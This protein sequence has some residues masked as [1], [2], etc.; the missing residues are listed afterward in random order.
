M[1]RV[2]VGI[3]AA[4]VAEPAVADDAAD[5][6]KLQEA[7]NA[8]SFHR[9]DK[10]AAKGDKPTLVVTGIRFVL[11]TPDE[12]Y[13]GV[14]RIDAGRSPRTIDLVCKG[15]ERRTLRGIYEWDGN[16]LRL[17]VRAGDRPDDF[18]PRP[19]DA[20]VIGLSPDPGENPYRTARVGDWV[21]Y[22]G[23]DVVM[24]HTVTAKTGETLTLT[25]D[26]TVGGKAGP[27]IE[28]PIDLTRPYPPP[29]APDPDVTTKHERLEV[30]TE[31]L[32]LGGKRYPCER[33]KA[34]TTVTYKEE[35]KDAAIVSVGTTWHCKDVPLG[36]AVKTET[37]LADG[38]KSVSVLSGYGRGK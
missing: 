31:T 23:G 18:R 14:F 36:G 24:R 21:E 22:A 27:A 3:L 25:I 10:A 29:A 35:G 12:T 26:Q 6:R 20:L 13:E 16:A 1:K 33:V 5:V 34:R 9:G 4:V 38:T 37:E 32:T 11:T 7:W 30:G 8:T 19:G 17:A 28:Q 2:L 15:K